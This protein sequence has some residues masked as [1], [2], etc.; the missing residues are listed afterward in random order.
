MAHFYA[1]CEVHGKCGE[2]RETAEKAAEDCN[3]HV[4][5]VSGPH[6]LV[7]PRLSNREIVNG[8]RRYSY[9]N[10]KELAIGNEK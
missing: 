4:A 6:G 8:I 10:L 3:N 2:N 1:Y 5:T 9:K 7:F